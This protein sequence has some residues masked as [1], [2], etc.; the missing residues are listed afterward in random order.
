MARVRIG[1]VTVGAVYPALAMPSV[2]LAC[3]QPPR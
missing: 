1:P 3:D 2:R